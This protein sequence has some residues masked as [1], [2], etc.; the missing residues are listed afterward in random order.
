SAASSMTWSGAS[1]PTCWRP[2]PRR[3]STTEA[4]PF[5]SLPEKIGKPRAPPRPFSVY[6]CRAGMRAMRPAKPPIGHGRV[7]AP[8]EN[9]KILIADDNATFRYALGEKLTSLGYE[10]VFA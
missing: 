6:P 3:T 8:G 2:T 1:T 4:R 7:D 5:P 9:V 10:V